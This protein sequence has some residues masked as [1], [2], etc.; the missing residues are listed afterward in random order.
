MQKTG[1]ITGVTMIGNYGS[2]TFTQNADGLKVR[3]AAP[4]Q[5]AYTLK[6][7]GLQTNPSSSTW[8]ASGNP[9]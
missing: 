9:Q 4:C 1:Q 6:I 3:F 5:C 7:T 2:L 8:T